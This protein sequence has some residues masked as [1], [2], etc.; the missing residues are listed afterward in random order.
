MDEDIRDRWAA[1]L[2]SGQYRQTQGT[3]RRDDAY[4]CLGVLCE[5][6]REMTGE[7]EWVPV[8]G[9]CYRFTARGNGNSGALPITVRDWAGLDDTHPRLPGDSDGYAANLNDHRL[10]F[11]G[12]AELVRK[13]PGKVTD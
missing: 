2:E 9:E 10:S 13:L 7:G 4:C 3:L 12:I 11:K 8:I 5:L 1:K 6:F